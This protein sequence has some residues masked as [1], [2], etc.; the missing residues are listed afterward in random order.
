MSV[1]LWGRGSR[2]KTPFCNECNVVDNLRAEGFA[3]IAREHYMKVTQ[4][5]TVSV[6]RQNIENHIGYG[7][8]CK[9][10]RGDY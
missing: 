7:K 2:F 3:R 6:Y 10:E 8:N 5:H 4:K 1:L 9:I